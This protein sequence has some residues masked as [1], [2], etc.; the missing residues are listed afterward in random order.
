MARQIHANPDRLL[1]DFLSSMLNDMIYDPVPVRQ[2]AEKKA[3]E[4]HEFRQFLKHH[5]KLGSKE[6]DRLVFGISERVCRLD[7][8]WQLLPG[9]V[10]HARWAGWKA[11]NT[12]GKNACATSAWL[13]P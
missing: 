7:E 12:A 11:R 8:V 1:L 3:N 2:M 4:N 13:S 6:V 9:S 5:P 10:A